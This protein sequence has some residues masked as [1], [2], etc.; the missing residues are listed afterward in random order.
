M[1]YI[2]YP[3]CIY[4]VSDC[5]L[6]LVGVCVCVTRDVLNLRVQDVVEASQN[7]SNYVFAQAST[8]TL[9]FVLHFGDFGYAMGKHW[10]W[11]KW[12][13]MISPGASLV[14]YMVSPGNHEYDHNQGACTYTYARLGSTRV[15]TSASASTIIL[16]AVVAS[17]TAV[18]VCTRRCVSLTHAWPVFH[19]GVLM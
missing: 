18:C 19:D 3:S 6:R 16:R 5:A 14:P 11:D 17:C 7:T 13:T 15:N 4:V 2:S 1:H 12:G 10:I 8:G 9:D